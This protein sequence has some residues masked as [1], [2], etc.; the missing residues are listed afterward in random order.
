MQHENGA[1]PSEEMIHITE[2]LSVDSQR[3]QI[4]CLGL[5]EDRLN[6]FGTTSKN[7]P[8]S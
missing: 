6:S 2:C 5:S 1:K 3:Q 8:E 7:P 4:F